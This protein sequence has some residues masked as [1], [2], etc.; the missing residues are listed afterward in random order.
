MIQL[1]LACS[2]RS[3]SGGAT[4]KDARSPLSPIPTPII[5]SLLFA[6]RASFRVATLLSERLEQAKLLQKIRIVKF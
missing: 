2:R 3:D 4:Q 1:S 6:L 5:D